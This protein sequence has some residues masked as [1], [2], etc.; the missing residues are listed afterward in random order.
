MEEQVPAICGL[1]PDA[2]R[3]SALAELCLFP[4]PHSLLFLAAELRG[5]AGQG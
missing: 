4:P 1:D 3:A 5:R 2:H